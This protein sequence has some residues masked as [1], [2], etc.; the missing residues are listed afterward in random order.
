MLANNEIQREN[1]SEP[2]ELVKKLRDIHEIKLAETRA[3]LEEKISLHK[4]EAEE[5]IDQIDHEMD[6]EIRELSDYK[7]MVLEIGSDNFS[8][9]NSGNHVKMKKLTDE[10]LRKATE[11]KQRSNGSQQ[12]ASSADFP[13]NGSQI[14]EDKEW[15][16]HL[17]TETKS[18]SMG[19][20]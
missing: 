3:N 10:L 1:F 6:K 7:A 16:D 19:I 12:K 5:K 13:P 9:Q 8:I 20:I 14:E 2:V 17:T 4:K 11:L 18:Q 15:T